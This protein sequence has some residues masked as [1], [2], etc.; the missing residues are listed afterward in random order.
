MKKDEGK[1]EKKPE[2]IEITEV[3]VSE[4]INYG[5]EPEFARVAESEAETTKPDQKP[6]HEDFSLI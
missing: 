3:K 1:V 2:A 6:A 4:N 5:D